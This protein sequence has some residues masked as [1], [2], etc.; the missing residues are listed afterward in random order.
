M[1]DDAAADRLEEVAEPRNDA[2]EVAASEVADLPEQPPLPMTGEPP[3]LWMESPEAVFFADAALAPIHKFDPESIPEPP[4]VRH[5]NFADAMLFTLML[6]VGALVATGGL[7]IAL[8]FHWFGLRNLDAAMK[9]TPVALGSQL[10]IYVL[11]LAVAVPFF[12]MVWGM[13]YFAGLHWHAATAY[14]LRYW[15]VGIA[16]LL[17]LLALAVGLVVKFPEHAPIDKMFGTPSDAWLLAGFG[18]LVAPFFEEMLFRG[19]LLPAVATAWDWCGERMS[20][21]RPQALDAAGNPVWSWG[22]RVFAAL[23]VSAPFAWMHSA[24]VA[25]SWGPLMLLYCVS[26]ALCAVRLAARSLAA[27]TLVHSAYNFMLFALM[28]AQTDGFQ[29]LDKM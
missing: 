17:N 24:Q 22:A 26:L 6:L 19:F 13:R 27:S 1:M 8:Y 10:A 25:D 4:V 3:A 14:R 12:R 29:H 18:V 21:A 11:G 15:L 23:A 16:F 5:P 28:F 7:G 2:E 20:G 9:S